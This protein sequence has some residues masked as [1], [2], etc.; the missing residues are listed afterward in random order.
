MKRFISIFLV[1]QL[2]L[3]TGCTFPFFGKA[4]EDPSAIAEGSE[5]IR[6]EEAGTENGTTVG[7]AGSEDNPENAAS[8]DSTNGAAGG[9]NSG[10]AGSNTGGDADG[11][12]GINAGN[13][14][15]DGEADDNTDDADTADADT[16]DG[17]VMAAD[18][19][20]GTAS[21]LT[22]VTD[23]PAEGTAAAYDSTK[24]AETAVLGAQSNSSSSSYFSEPRRAVTVYY[25][26]GDGCIVP[27]TRWIELQP[28]I[29]RA[30]LSLTID[31]ALTR[32]ELAYYGVYPIIP[33]E[34]DILGIDVRDGIALID[35]D[36]SLLNYG[37]ALA[38]RNIIASIVYTLTE[39]ETIERVRIMIN[40]Y[41]QGILKFGTDI[42]EALGRDDIFI[43]ADS[44]GVSAGADKVDLFLMK[45]ANTGFIYP[46]PVSAVKTGEADNL[47]ELL[48]KQL[49]AV[50][51]RDG[52]ISE[53]PD[54]A[55]L[56]ESSTVSGV[57]TLNFS[58]EFLDYGGSAREE[59]ILKQL[60]YTLRQ[61]GEVSKIRIT[62]EGREV[63]L[64]EGTD[65]SGGL[66][67]PS[68]INDVI[69]R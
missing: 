19:D 37:S 42:T 53:M 49:L 3:L 66:A 44:S 20:I 4:K 7:P 27:M 47:P 57:M 65:I 46:V 50:Q 11:S 62:V 12:T 58:K 36:R 41:P 28:G 30:A 55:V 18:E 64:P 68:T 15:A 25:Q 17:S 40:G 51:A 54:G 56:L 13:A 34:T 63:E 45:Q 10:G 39:F 23:E 9:I 61:C 1:I 35:F 59:G 8:G 33:A 29:A 31:S 22:T 24:Q 21:S 38:E 16:A 43:N 69:D 26:D 6:A 67:I 52:M 14:A 5:M 2:I 32:E 48:V 60:A